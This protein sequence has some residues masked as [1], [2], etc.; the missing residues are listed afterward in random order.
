MKQ[1]WN[2]DWQQIFANN[3]LAD[4]DAI[5]DLTTEWF[6]EPNKRRGGWSGVIKLDLN[7]AEGKVSVFIKRQ[8]NHI[9]RT[10]LHPVRGM[11][12]F[13][14]EYQNIL[15]MSKHGLP[16]M[17]LAFFA[18]RINNGNLQAILITKALDDYIPLE[19]ERFLAS[20]DLINNAQ[21]KEKLLV[22]VADTLR[23]IHRHH[24]QHNCL[25]LKHI[26]VRPDGDG[27][28]IK[29]IDLEKLKWRFFK[30]QAVFRD[31]YT[32]YR[33]AKGWSRKDHVRLF[34][35]YRQEKQLSAKSKTL[36]HAIEKRILDKRR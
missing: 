21:H 18:K 17:E 27:W 7:T 10:L 12:T 8:E 14:R 33:H 1:H 32:L 11:P 22:A 36:W 2:K 4:F 24:F 26:F 5:W 34:Q 31:L 29:L 16:I 30:Q 19:S 6:E 28:D 13:Q 20:G 35:A 15:R 9:T 3:N 25:Y 23:Q